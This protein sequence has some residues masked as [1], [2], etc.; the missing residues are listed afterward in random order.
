MFRSLPLPWKGWDGNFP[1]TLD[2]SLEMEGFDVQDLVCS[3]GFLVGICC[4][5]L[6]G[7][8]WCLLPLEADKPTSGH[9]RPQAQGLATHIRAEDASSRGVG[10]APL[11]AL[12]LEETCVVWGQCMGNQG[13]LQLWLQP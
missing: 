7:A 3:F 11:K 12:A 8:R 1:S 5:Q 4:L 9:S 2:F 6:H 13:F 10:R